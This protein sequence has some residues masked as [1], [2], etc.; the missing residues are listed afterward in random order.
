MQMEW[1]LAF[2][3]WLA[4]VLIL[5]HLIGYPALL[6]VLKRLVKNPVKKSEISPFVSIIIPAY[7][8]GGVIREKVN[9]VIHSH[10]PAD[11]YE[12][13]VVDDGSTDNT[14]EQALIVSDPRV[15]IDQAEMRGGKMS[16]LKRGVKLAKGDVIVISDAE[17]IW[18]PDSLNHLISN[19]ADPAVGCAS[20]YHMMMGSN[21]AEA[22]EN[23]YWRYESCIKKL[24]SAI[25][26]TTAATG[27]LLAIR[28]SL[29]QWPDQSI[30]NDD[31]LMA[32]NAASHGYRVIFDPSAVTYESGSSSISIEYH[33]KSRIAAGRWQIFGQVF[34][35]AFRNP[36]FVIAF[37]SHKMLRL[38]IFPLMILAFLSSLGRVFMSQVGPAELLSLFGLYSPWGQL[39]LFVQVLF[40]LLAGFG[41]LLDHFGI[42]IK[43][44]YLPYYFLNAQIASLSG[45]YRFSTGRQ[46]V[47]WRKVSR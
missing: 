11:C 34:K 9:S 15:V 47:L 7:N 13:I 45:F 30:I 37:F 19:F 20:G 23:F 14:A 41:A 28:K 12:V 18:K 22:N 25:H 32:L 40:Y 27:G 17:A 39:A 33:R 4:A 3:F 1:G 44:L 43:L 46:T 26:S 36:W 21:G 38:L 6:F 24:E 29:F 8:E 42:R 2:L 10:Y 35:L 31:F 5:Y 16:A